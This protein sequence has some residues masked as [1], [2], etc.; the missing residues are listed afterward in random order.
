MKRLQNRAVDAQPTW[1]RTMALLCLLMV[2]F[3]STAQAVHVHGQWLPHQ[4]SQVDIAVD[5]SQVSGEAACPICVAMH[6]ALP[7]AAAVPATILVADKPT[8]M[9]AAADRVPD[10]TWHFARFSRPPPQEIL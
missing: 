3:S 8:R 7:V 6:S 2:A 9:A 10:E 1:L 4:Q 5:A